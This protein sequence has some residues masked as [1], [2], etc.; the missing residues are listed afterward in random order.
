MFLAEEVKEAAYKGLVCPV[1]DYGS[2]VWDPRGVVLQGEL[3]S[4]QKH[5]ARIVTGNYSY[6]PGSM[7]GILAV[8]RSEACLLGIQAAHVWHILLWRLGHE[9][10]S[11]TI[12]PLLLIQEEQLS[13]T[14][15][16]MCT[17]YW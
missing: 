15:E 3:E 9:N 5:A 17:K 16:R 13:V 6:E 2:S 1:L 11:T 12:L 4:V 14:G 10:I 8:A 7:T